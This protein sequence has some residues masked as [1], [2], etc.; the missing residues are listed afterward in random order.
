[1]TGTIAIIVASYGRPRMLAEA[2]YSIRGA[3]QV[4]IADD[5]SDF[6]VQ[7]LAAKINPPGLTLVLNDPKPPGNRMVEPSCGKLLNRALKSVQT[8]Y[9]GYLCDDDLFDLDWVKNARAA[10]DYYS[11]FHLVRGDWRLFNDGESR[12]GSPLCRFVFQPPLT[13]GNFVHRISCATEEACWWGERSLAI[14]DSVMLTHYLEV[15]R[16]IPNWYGAIDV[17]AGWRREHPKTISNNANS[18]D[19][20]SSRAQELFA[21]GRME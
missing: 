10:L 14:H 15:H 16:R 21:A 3:D 11:S 5:G 9:V 1:M 17:L 19:R 2:L 8:D 4:I 7:A 6:D 18:S 12:A 20:Y 13:T